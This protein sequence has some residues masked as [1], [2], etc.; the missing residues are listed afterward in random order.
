MTKSIKEDKC[1]TVV[2]FPTCRG[3]AVLHGPLRHRRHHFRG[4]QLYGAVSEA[5]QDVQRL[6]GHQ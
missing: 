5:R 2:S 4:R 3:S 1:T 6:P